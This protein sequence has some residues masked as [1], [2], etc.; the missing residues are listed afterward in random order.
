MEVL[1]KVMIKIFRTKNN[2]LK[3]VI[4]KMDLIPYKNIKKDC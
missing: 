1:E 4:N 2:N 3:K